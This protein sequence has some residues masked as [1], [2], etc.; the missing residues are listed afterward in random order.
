M[1]RYQRYQTFRTG[2]LLPRT[3]AWLALACAVILTLRAPTVCAQGAQETALARS[4]FEEGVAAADAGQWAKAADRFGRAHSL[5]PTPGIAFNWASALLELGKLVEAGERL[6]A[7]AYDP[8]AGDELRAQSQEKLA[9]IAPRVALLTLRVGEPNAGLSVTI[10]EHVL[11]R[12]AWGS[13]APVDPGV[14]S[15]SLLRGD[16]TLSSESITLSDG[17]R[18]ELSLLVP[19]APESGSAPVAAA[20]DPAAR[21][22]PR[23]SERKPL[24]KNW[25]MWTA[26]GVVAIGGV[27][28]G[29][30]LAQND[31][32][33]PAPVR[34]DT[35][36]A[37]IR[38]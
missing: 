30:L 10:D 28:T 6:R 26:V 24:Y 11:P 36:P 18:R 4:L 23:P 32:K 20:I 25:M 14:H 37:V 13:V 21:E 31:P 8:A 1:M 19:D 16:E 27:V 5:K 22:E 12:V 34:G 3:L 29:M 9:A 2:R 33:E 7:V 15:V 17:E 38:W 35:D